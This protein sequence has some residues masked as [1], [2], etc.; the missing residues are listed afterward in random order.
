MSV[1]MPQCNRSYIELL[2]HSIKSK[3]LDEWIQELKQK[4][5]KFERIVHFGCASGD[6]TFALLLELD[7]DMIIGVDRDI[8]TAERK[9]NDIITAIDNCWLAYDYLSLNDKRWWDN[10]LPEKLKNKLIPKYVKEPD[11]TKPIIPYQI[12]GDYY[13]LACCSNFLYIIQRDCGEIGVG[14]VINEMKRVIKS[15]GYIVADEPD[16][17]IKERF[18]YLFER[19]GLQ[20]VSNKSTIYPSGNSNTTYTYK[21]S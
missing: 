14:N 21:N 16:E 18:S 4:H 8:M 13:N 19:A 11:C 7:A 12:Q 1:N 17:G 3:S 15:T 5:S 2:L 20:K 9:A 6:Q 10:I